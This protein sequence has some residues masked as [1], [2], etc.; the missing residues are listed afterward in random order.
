MEYNSG[1]GGTTIHCRKGT[2]LGALQFGLRGMRIGIYAI[3]QY[4][5]GRLRSNAG[6]NRHSAGV[7]GLDMVGK[8]QRKGR[9]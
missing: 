3:S 4:V 9:L 2:I 5:V 1:R 7:C 6:V 8:G